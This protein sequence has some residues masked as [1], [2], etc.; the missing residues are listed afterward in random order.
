MSPTKAPFQQLIGQT[1]KALNAILDR[2][3][4]GAISEPQWV[5]LVL[6]A[7][8]GDSAS[9]DQVTARLAHALK[10]DTGT[11]ADHLGGL[12]AKGLVQPVPESGSDLALTKA[13]HELLGRI[14]RQVGEIT[15]RLWGDL[16]A[17][18]MDVT[19]GVLATILERTDSELSAAS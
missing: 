9:R 6:I 10:A 2:Q 13:G 5:A 4:A 15:Q 7:G 3:L 16:P 17:A 12:L 19:R 11:A 14:Q 8:S 18:E 1:E